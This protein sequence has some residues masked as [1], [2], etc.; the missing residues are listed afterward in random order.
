MTLK[1]KRLSD[2]D[3][4]SLYTRAVQSPETDVEFFSQVYEE[5]RKGTKPRVLRED[6][7]GTFR[8]AIEW[9]KASSKA[10]AIGI[11][12]DLEPLEYGRTHY[13]PALSPKQKARITTIQAN[14]MSSSLPKSDIIAAMNF[15]HY[16]FKSRLL[17]KKYL[18]QCWKSLNPNG[19]MVM[20]AFGGTLC[21]ESNLEET[22]FAKEGFSY[23]WDQEFFDPIT[24]HA[25]FHIHFKRKGEGRRSK[26]F[27]YDWRMWT[28]PELREILLDA[29]FVRTHVY[30]EGTT[31]KGEGNGVFK[32][33]EKGEECE[34][35]I[36]YVIGER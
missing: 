12:L 15:S 33:A 16:I 5:C 26:V 29:G 21:Q 3:K 19:I 10:R 32:R 35:W 11:D 8:L 1:N 13:L 7:C 2:F 34:S 28:L 24:H 25:I 36:A 30:W 18:R 4:Y 6:F 9:V 14:V 27:S 23:L 17:M 31:R 22:V 20:D